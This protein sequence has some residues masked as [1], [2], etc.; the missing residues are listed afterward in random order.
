MRQS[1]LYKRVYEHLSQSF[2]NSPTLPLVQFLKTLNIDSMGR[3]LTEEEIGT[4]ESQ[5]NTSSD[6]SCL[7]VEPSFSPQ[8]IRNSHF[9][10]AN[11]LPQFSGTVLLEEGLELETGIYSSLIHNCVLGNACIRNISLLSNYCIDDKVCLMNSGDI[12]WNSGPFPTLGTS[13]HPGTEEKMRSV[14]ITEF[15]S[16]ESAFEA[17]KLDQE[18]QKAIESYLEACKKDWVLSTGYIGRES[19]ITNTPRIGNTWIGS[20]VK[21]KGAQSIQNSFLAGILEGEE[22][23]QKN[24]SIVVENGCVIQNSLVQ[25]NVKIS[26]ANNIEHSFLCSQST[27]GVMAF[28]SHS[29]IAE[30]TSVEKAEVFSSLVGPMVGLHHQSLLISALW[31]QG[32]GNI[33][34]GANVGS[35]HT[36]RKPDQEITPGEGL[37]FGLGCSIKFP[38]NLQQSPYS[39]IAAGVTLPPQKIACPFSLINTSKSSFQNEIFPGW[40][41]YANPYALFRNIY[42]IQ[43]REKSTLSTEELLFPKCFGQWTLSALELL[44]KGFSQNICGHSFLSEENRKKAIQGYRSY[45]I[46]WLWCQNQQELE[47]SVS[48]SIKEYLRQT[49]GKK[50]FLL[51][52]KG[53]LASLATSLE[54]S[55]YKDFHKGEQVFNDYST[56]HSKGDKL[57]KRALMDIR[58]WIQMTP[59]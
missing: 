49:M 9:S 34:H 8:K 38:C 15:T 12:T 18:E 10:G 42:K 59:Q 36:G 40:M 46:C 58:R 3:P 4:L 55:F 1:D 17:A 50:D 2:E 26:G 43:D 28:I 30:N 22:E 25:T 48:L 14:W 29:L 6:W 45:L 13:I 33:G 57:L 20:F 21:I 19:C 37:F 5:G 23:E 51:E 44:E 56:F 32:R 47:N 41:W 54:N 52:N 35:N 7:R 53:T 39:I 27:V 24:L 16:V 11:Y 31:P